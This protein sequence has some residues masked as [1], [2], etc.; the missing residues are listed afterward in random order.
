MLWI[1]CLNLF[2]KNPHKI[3]QFHM[4]KREGTHINVVFVIYLFK[5]KNKSDFEYTRIEDT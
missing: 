5:Y 2:K 3:K 4:K 1:W